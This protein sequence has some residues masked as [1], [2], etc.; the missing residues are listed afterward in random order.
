MQSKL[1]VACRLAAYRTVVAMALSLIGGSQISFAEDSQVD[2]IFFET[3]TFQIGQRHLATYLNVSEIEQ[4]T[5]DWG[6]IE[7]I[8]QALSDLYALNVLA[9]EAI[10]YEPVLITEET[11][12]LKSE[13]MMKTELARRLLLAKLDLAMASVSIEPVAKE[14]YL[15]NKSEFVSSEEVTVRHLLIETDSRSLREAMQ[16]ILAVFNEEMSVEEFSEMVSLHS[17]DSAAESN[18]TLTFGRGQTEPAFEKAA[19][20][21]TESGEIS[22]IVVTRHG[23]HLMQLVSRQKGKLKTFEEIKTPLEEKLISEMRDKILG[24]LRAEARAYKP[25]GLIIH[26]DNIDAFMKEIGF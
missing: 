5:Q 3:D 6:S 24:G 1:I 21:L 4:E 15:A 26:Q 23:V 2:R 18:G 20:A 7:R 10:S 14:Y 22:D 25:D 9:D 12:R 8:K 13:E 17:D 19:F 11:L 16:I